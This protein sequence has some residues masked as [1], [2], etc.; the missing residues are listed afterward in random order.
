MKNDLKQK[1]LHV[2]SEAKS[3]ELGLGFWG[4]IMRMHEQA[5]VRIIKL[6]CAS[7]IMHTWVSTK[8]P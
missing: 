1:N 5:C 2:E 4:R 8:K 3:E 7:K 6:M